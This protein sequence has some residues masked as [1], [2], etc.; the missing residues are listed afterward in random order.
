MVLTKKDFAD[1]RIFEL[2][3][4]VWCSHDELKNN[5]RYELPS[6]NFVLKKIKQQ[7]SLFYHRATDNYEKYM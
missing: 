1:L 7:K 2:L 3:Q 6:I 5:E 4:N